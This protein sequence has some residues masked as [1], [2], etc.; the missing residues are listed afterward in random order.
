MSKIFS[1]IEALF[2]WLCCLF[3][4]DQT[5]F[6][7]AKIIQV[8]A[9]V[10]AM[11]LFPF[12]PSLAKDKEKPELQE[13]W[14]QACDSAL[15]S[16][17][18]EEGL[19]FDK[20]NESLQTYGLISL[21]DEEPALERCRDEVLQD[22]T[23]YKPVMTL[24]A[25]LW[26]QS[27]YWDDKQPQSKRQW[28]LFDEGIQ[29][30]ERGIKT[31]SDPEGKLDAYEFLF[32]F[33]RVK[34]GLTKDEGYR[35][36]ALRIGRELSAFGRKTI[37]KE[38]YGLLM[39]SNRDEAIKALMEGVKAQDPKSLAYAQFLHLLGGHVDIF[40]NMYSA[41][42]LR[43]FNE[44][45]R[46]NQISKKVS[47][48]N[49]SI[50]E[51]AYH[52]WGIGIPQN[53]E[54]ARTLYAQEL[55]TSNKE[56]DLI[57]A[58][59]EG[60]IWENLPV[61]SIVRFGEHLGKV[62][63]LS[64]AEAEE[65]DSK[66]IEKHSD[67]A[68]EFGFNLQEVKTEVDCESNKLCILNRARKGEIKYLKLRASE[69]IKR[70]APEK[71]WDWEL[72]SVRAHRANAASKME[73]Q[74]LQKI[75]QKLSLTEEKYDVD[76]GDTNLLIGLA[77][78]FGLGVEKDKFGG[79]RQLE[80]A[81]QQGNL[82]AAFKLSDIFNNKYG[83]GEPISSSIRMAYYFSRALA[84][85]PIARYPYQSR[86]SR[87]S[88][89]RNDKNIVSLFSELGKTT[90]PH[91]SGQYFDEDLLLTK[92]RESDKQMSALWISM[93]LDLY[94]DPTFPQFSVAKTERLFELVN[95]QWPDV[96]LGYLRSQAYILLGNAFSFGIG[97]KR[98]SSR[99]T[100]FYRR[101]LSESDISDD[102]K[103]SAH[104]ELGRIL[105]SGTGVETDV[106]QAKKH[107]EE[108]LKIDPVHPYGLIHLAQIY[109]KGLGIPRN[110]KKAHDFL[111]TAADYE[112][113]IAMLMLS[114]IYELGVGVEPDPRKALFWISRIGEITDE[115]RKVARQLGLSDPKASK[116]AKL[117]QLRAH[118][119]NI[120]EE[121]RPAGK[122]VA[123]L[124]GVSDYKAG[125][126]IDLRTPGQDVRA[127]GALLK[128]KY[129]FET[130]YLIDPTRS[131]ITKSL[132]VL[133]NN[134]SQSDSLLIYYAGHG[135]EKYGDGY[136]LASDSET[137]V[138]TAWISNDYITRKLKAIKAT[139][140]LVVSDS[141]FSG[142]ISRG[143]KIERQET[144]NTYELFQRTKSRMV[145]T[146]GNLTPVL[147]GGGGENSLFARAFLESLT[148]LDGNFSA[149]TLFDKL[150]KTVVP[151]A[152]SKG[153]EQTPTFASL[154]AAGHIGPDFVFYAN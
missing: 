137:D 11:I 50:S 24:A 105:I 20:K 134:L 33:Y 14:D 70:T 139:N 138:D 4:E 136:W 80:L 6:K 8:S 31:I 151:D 55:S 104:L 57:I 117:G 56:K 103:V 62:G 96:K 110:M 18:N 147:D 125:S 122:N 48:F 111:F 121:I 118:I 52:L 26:Q 40:G 82:K 154:T 123:L 34:Y 51:S 132:S 95:K 30:L 84:L 75:I 88:F 85:K 28:L 141:C 44:A 49:R 67:F 133:E 129:G 153:V 135:I 99:A 101:A 74:E 61:L 98:D 108:V 81:A 100:N 2:C 66:I 1:Q 119:R 127:I 102:S 76:R 58:S 5:F 27:G 130:E 109:M 3:E 131:E 73:L 36:E 145:I 77:K 87:P 90:L 92:F 37:Q 17:H 149:T 150:Q 146:S 143:I 10:A 120:S 91:S 124:I 15:F 32:Q 41:P 152:L 21:D 60:A 46:L 16:F 86:Y 94:T 142:T 22:P 106:L 116:L 126:M 68:K 112:D 89:E 64:R 93:L 42:Q 115:D 148:S 69:L 53:L 12:C 59:I 63:E 97:L 25:F 38:L 140:I 23:N 65:I 45:F 113:P 9:V 47:Y 71:G 7:T 83:S 128:E 29:V 79:L 54:M 35:L 107:F 13:I 144:Q 114:E 78:F 19:Y 72:R 43:N 39:L